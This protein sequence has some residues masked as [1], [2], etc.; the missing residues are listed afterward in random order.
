MGGEVLR[1]KLLAFFAR[2]PSHLGL[3]GGSLVV[4]H[5]G[6]K[7]TMI[8]S[9]SDQVRRFC[10]YGDTSGERDASGLPIRY[11]WAAEY[12]GRTTI[13]YGH[14]PVS[15]AHWVNNTLCLDTG[16]CFGGRLSCLRWPERE[17]VSV[18][19]KDV[20]ATRL[21]PFGHPPV[22]PELAR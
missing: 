1:E 15:Q 19:A 3:D 21:R 10:L 13:V 12:K 5:A 8:G 18:G 2:L 9:T 6:I 20:H 11:H 7:E 4:A 14:T 22:R 17:I 16:C